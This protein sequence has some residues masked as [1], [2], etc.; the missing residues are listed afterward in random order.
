MFEKVLH[1][2]LPAQPGCLALPLVQRLD[3]GGVLPLSHVEQVDR[4]SI[5][6]AYVCPA[7]DD[8]KHADKEGK[9]RIGHVER[10]LSRPVAAP[11]AVPAVPVLPRGV[12]ARASRPVPPVPVRRATGAPKVRLHSPSNAVEIVLSSLVGIREN[13]VRG[14]DKSVALELGWVWNSVVDCMRV[15][16]GMIDLDKLVESS[17]VVGGS[18]RLAK[19]LIRGRVGSRG[20]LVSIRT[21]VLLLGRLAVVDGS[22]RSTSGAR[23]AGSRRSKRAMAA[24]RLGLTWRR[25]AV[26]EKAAASVQRWSGF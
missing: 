8:G 26:K 3:D 1:P 19:D 4:A 22:V 11:L 2:V 13:I 25:R 6:P 17:L 18:F 24:P 5:R 21:G 15:A 10:F 16:V 7:S 9:G 12:H 20:P 14:D 23:R